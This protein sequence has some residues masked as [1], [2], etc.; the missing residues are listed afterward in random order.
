MKAHIKLTYNGLK[1]I[2]IFHLF[3][4]MY[5]KSKKHLNFAKNMD[6]ALRFGQLYHDVLE[7]WLVG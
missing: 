3:Q 7:A 2:K 6:F 4:K 5:L 1:E